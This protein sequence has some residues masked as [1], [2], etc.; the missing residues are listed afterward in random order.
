MQQKVTSSHGYHKY[1]KLPDN[2]EKVNK[3]TNK[4]YKQWRDRKVSLLD[5][6]IKFI[7]SELWWKSLNNKVKE[8]MIS[9]YGTNKI[10]KS[11]YH[12]WTQP[13]GYKPKKTTNISILEKKFKN[14]K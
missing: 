2:L 1:Y 8:N 4:L 13:V 9:K 14:S 7:Q 10:A 6:R 3:R 5:K 11:R 12:Y